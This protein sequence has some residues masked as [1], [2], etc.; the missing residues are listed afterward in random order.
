MTKDK[1]AEHIETLRTH[2]PAPGIAVYV[3]PVGVIIDHDAGA[4]FS[5][6]VKTSGM[7][8][9]HNTS[10]KRSTMV[11]GKGAKR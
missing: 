4:E 9:S 2:H 3:T 10:D 1:Q 6:D 11:L 7:I 8:V 5:V